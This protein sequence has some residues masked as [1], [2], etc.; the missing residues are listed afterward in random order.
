M[1]TGIP[2]D[3]AITQGEKSIIRQKF[4]LT[5]SKPLI[6][7][8]GGSQGSRTINQAIVKIL[9][10]LL[11]KTQVIH[12]TGRDLFDE[13]I[14]TASEYGIKNSR[15]GYHAVPFVEHE[16]M[17]DVYAT[18]DVIICRSGATTIAEV[19]ANKKAAIFIPLASAA[20]DEQRLNAYELAKVGGALV[21]EESNLGPN[22]LLGKIE[23][24][25]NDKRL[26]TKMGENAYVFYKPNATK[27]IVDGV[28]DLL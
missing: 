20:N 2:V 19:A 4:D 6:F 16:M 27:N 9:P 18:T 17:K 7:I 1:V 3:S 5:D 22:I 26:Q 21:L 14:E 10:E 15:Q 28:L 25:L 12:Q 23:K 24:L 11:K 8:T 13:T